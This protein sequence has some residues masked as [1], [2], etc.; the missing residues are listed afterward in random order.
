MGQSECVF[1]ERMV[2]EGGG[3]GWGWVWGG[4]KCLVSFLLA[5]VAVLLSSVSLLLLHHT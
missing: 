2:L 3:W 4:G 1:H 5:S